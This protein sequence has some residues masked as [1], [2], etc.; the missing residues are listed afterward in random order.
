MVFGKTGL[1]FNGDCRNR[2][3]GYVSNCFPAGVEGWNRENRRVRQKLQPPLRKLEIRRGRYGGDEVCEAGREKWSGERIRR[4]WRRRKEQDFIALYA[5]LP[6]WP[7]L[8]DGDISRPRARRWWLLSA[9][10]SHHCFGPDKS[11]PLT[12]STPAYFFSHPW[13]TL[14]SRTRTASSLTHCLEAS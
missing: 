8:V 4:G 14:V 11:T 10:T 7:S 2:H 5:K 3:F 12:N 13:P 6:M 1:V 9:T